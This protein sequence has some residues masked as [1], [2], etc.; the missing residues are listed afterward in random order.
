MRPRTVFLV[1]AIATLIACASEPAAP[2]LAPVIDAASVASNPDNVLSAIVTVTARHADSVVVRYHLADAEAS[3]SVTP[4]AVAS[5]VNSLPVLGLLPARRY[6]LR[7]VAYGEGGTVASAPLDLLTGA[8]PSDLPSYTTSGADPSPGYVVMAAGMYGLVID[9]TGRVVWYHRF[10]NGPWLNFMAQPNGRYVAR[11]VTPDPADIESWVEIDPA[12]NTTRT[13]GCALGLQ[14]RFHDLIAEPGGGYWILCDETR[15]MDLT[16]DGGVANAKV[17]GTAIQHVSAAGE[18][19][20]HWSP[21]DH[22]LIT[23]VDLEARTGPNVNWTHGN[24]L[25]LDADGNLLVSFRN[26]NEITMIDSHTG[27]V[28]WRLGGRRNQFLLGDGANWFAGQHSVRVLGRNQFLILDNIGDATESRAER[29][30]LDAPSGLA[31]MLESRG[32]VPAVR[33]LIGGSVQALPQNH[34]LVSF[35]TEG[36]VEEYDEA[37]AVRWRIEGAPG[38]VFRAQR[39]ESLYRPGVNAAR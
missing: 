20:F 17:T 12:G 31:W 6:V 24:S 1:T 4:A 13:F 21:F 29:W 16:Q 18:L 34:L 23:D 14:P 28:L 2:P 11:L 32:S 33:T 27:A 26:L 25:D 15:T 10:A 36:R 9:N 19:L 22:F 39:I 5:Q 37:G 3:D 38:Y 35:G 7:A 8:L 30:T